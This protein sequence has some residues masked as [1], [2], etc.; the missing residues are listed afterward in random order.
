MSKVVRE[1]NTCMP[2]AINLYFDRVIFET[3]RDFKQKQRALGA[4]LHI[5]IPDKYALAMINKIELNHRIYRRKTIFS[6]MLH[7]KE[8]L[9][10]KLPG[11]HKRA[12]IDYKR[13]G[14]DEHH[15]E[16]VGM[17]D[18]EMTFLRYP[19]RTTLPYCN[20]SI[21]RYIDRCY[22]PNDEGYYFAIYI[23]LQ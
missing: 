5:Y 2:T 23:Y 17:C 1:A 18:G 10:F 22:E 8:S 9:T 21:S 11:N 19:E 7:R 4:R 15:T 12:I 16:A 20:I 13:I 3:W 14:N 6:T